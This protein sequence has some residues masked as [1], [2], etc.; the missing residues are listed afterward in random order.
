MCRSL[1]D[2]CMNCH[3]RGCLV[4]I[5]F[6]IEKIVLEKGKQKLSAC[7]HNRL[8]IYHRQTR[9]QPSLK[10]RPVGRNENGMKENPHQVKNYPDLETTAGTDSY[11]LPVT[12]IGDCDLKPIATR[13]WIMIDLQIRIE[14][15]I[16]NLDLVVD[17]NILI[18]HDCP[19]AT[20][21]DSK[22]FIRVEKL[23]I[24]RLLAVLYSI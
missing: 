17:G 1:A 8:S 9:G 14:G 23:S 11:F 18:C 3:R 24:G 15:H 16:F 22:L 13:T 5:R 2:S 4:W 7:I 20:G 21:M 19:L 6:V 10:R 12:K